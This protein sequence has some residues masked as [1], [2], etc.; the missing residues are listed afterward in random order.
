MHPERTVDEALS[1]VDEEIYR[2]Q[3]A[4]PPSEELA[5]AV[6]QARALFAYGSESTTNQAFWLVLLK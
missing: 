4:P 3:D 5:R 1:A 2:L 6:K